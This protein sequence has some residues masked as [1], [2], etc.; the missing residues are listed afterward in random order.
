MKSSWRSFCAPII[1]KVLEETKGQSEKEI[2]AAL[3]EKYPFG[4]RAMHPYKIWLDEIDRQL[5][6]ERRRSKIFKRGRKKRPFGPLKDGLDP[7]QG[8]LF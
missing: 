8:T 4:Q 5:H 3:S 2:R 7:K 1:A 6:P